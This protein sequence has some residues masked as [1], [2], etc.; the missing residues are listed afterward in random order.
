VSAAEVRRVA[1]VSARWGRNGL[2]VAAAL[3]PV[4][5]PSGSGW[6]YRC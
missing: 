4:P 2:T 1:V 3:K 5:P 6:T